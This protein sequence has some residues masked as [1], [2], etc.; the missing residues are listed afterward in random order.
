MGIDIVEMNKIVIDYDA[1]NVYSD[2]LESVKEYSDED[3]EDIE[4]DGIG[5]NR[6][7]DPF[8]PIGVENLTKIC[9]I[10]YQQ[11]IAIDSGELNFSEVKEA[12]EHAFS[13]DEQEWW[14]FLDLGVRSV[15]LAI[16]EIG[17][18]PFSSCN[19]GCFQDDDKRHSE[20]YPLVAFYG[21]QSC[22]Q[23]VENAAR[24]NGCGLYTN[25]GSLVLYTNDI[26]NLNRVA[27]DLLESAEK[28]SLGISQSRLADFEN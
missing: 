10:E 24:Q 25:G 4:L 13:N 9:T 5:G 20:H 27:A 15:V 2:W 3:E 28:Q 12:E 17:G 8:D 11:I 26:V 18:F 16:R 6:L 21:D 7:F 23:I 22:I 19:A 1:K 14:M